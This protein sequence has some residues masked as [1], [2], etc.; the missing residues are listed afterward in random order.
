MR[1]WSEIWRARV[2]VSELRKL[3]DMINL[4][5]SPLDGP[6]HIHQEGNLY[7]PGSYSFPEGCQQFKLQLE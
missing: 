5:K 1:R 4:Y 2:R 6:H 3:Q 7:T